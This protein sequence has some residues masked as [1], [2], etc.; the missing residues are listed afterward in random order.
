MMEVLRGTALALV[1]GS[2][3]GH[4]AA[5]GR[6]R[7]PHVEPVEQIG[8]ERQPVDGGPPA[9]SAAAAAGDEL[10]EAELLQLRHAALR[11]RRALAQRVGELALAGPHA[12][13]V[14]V[15]VRRQEQ[16]GALQ[17][18]GELLRIGEAA[19][20]VLPLVAADGPRG[21]WVG[22]GSGHAIRQPDSYQ[23]RICSRVG[24]G[25][26]GAVG[27]S[28]DRFRFRLSHSLQS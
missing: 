10:K 3:E 14:R 9:G 25:G 21:V 12:G 27:W 18:V 7:R 17:L 24:S 28:T 8:G 20:D 6:A 4:R 19:H 22:F 5:R 26:A 1:E 2:Y 11:G 15:G 16:G 13:A 23:A